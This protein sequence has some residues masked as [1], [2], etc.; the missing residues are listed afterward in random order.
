MI[1]V[2]DAGLNVEAKFVVD[3][4]VQ[5]VREVVCDVDES[6][7]LL[8]FRYPYVLK[9][10]SNGTHAKELSKSKFPALLY[11]HFIHFLQR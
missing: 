10:L 2:K 6:D 1:C 8:L 9:C 5:K 4:T 11:F 7:S 3:R